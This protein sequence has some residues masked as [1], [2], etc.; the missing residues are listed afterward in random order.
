MINVISKYYQ[1]ADDGSANL[2]F[3][4]CGDTDRS[5]IPDV[6]EAYFEDKLKSLKN[7]QIVLRG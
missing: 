2:M 5:R 3:L 7:I 6:L 4:H 1:L